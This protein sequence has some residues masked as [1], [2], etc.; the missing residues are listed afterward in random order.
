M[1]LMAA[2]ALTLLVSCRPDSPVVPMLTVDA[3][4]EITFNSDGTGGQ[5][6]ISVSTNQGA[7][8]YS[9]TPV[10]D[11]G[12]LRAKVVG[13]LLC[14]AAEPNGDP[15]TRGQVNIVFTAGEAAPVVVEVG[16]RGADVYLFVTPDGDLDIDMRTSVSTLTV[17]SSF[18]WSVEVTGDDVSWCTVSRSDNTLIVRATTNTAAAPRTAT[19]NFTAG[20][21]SEQV[22]VTQ[23]AYDGDTYYIDGEVVKLKSANAF[24]SNMKGVNIIVSGDGYTVDQ[25]QRG[26]GKYYEDMMAAWQNMLSIPPYSDYAEYFNVYMIAAVSNEEGMSCSSPA[27]N[28]DTKFGTIWEGGTSTGINCNHA[29]VEQ[30]ARKVTEL[31]DVD[32]HDLTFIMPINEDRYAGTCVTYFAGFSISMCPVES[33]PGEFRKVI[34]HEAGGHGF[35]QLIDEYIYY[36]STLPDGIGQTLRNRKHQYGI[37]ANIDFDKNVLNTTWAGYKTHSDQSV[38]DKYSMVDAFEGAY[39]YRYGIWRPESNSCMNDNVLY[40]NAPSRWAIVSRISRIAGLDIDFDKFAVNEVI[41]PNPY[42]A[43]PMISTGA[44]FV[45][46]GEPIFVGPDGKQSRLGL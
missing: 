17:E 39:M 21:L 30:W 35:G 46:L 25:M 23:G 45:P 18:D 20:T 41:P 24:G 38:V 12:W 32:L 9:V 13:D 26:S 22:T 34:C 29:F 7:W 3:P 1:L 8:N 16:Q 33:M 44:A 31:S 11:D 36:D 37:Y 28:V 19:L 42:P 43:P 6:F 5:A 40:Y 15:Q 2:A 27:K 10:T 4:S 14:L